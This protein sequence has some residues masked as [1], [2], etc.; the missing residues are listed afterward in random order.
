MTE[1]LPPR[2][3]IGVGAL[4]GIDGRFLLIRRGHPPRQGCW[5]LP[6]GRQEAGE[7]VEQAGRREIREET[8]VSIRVVDVLAVVDLMGG[9]DGAGYHYTVIDLEAEWTD[10][11]AV[12]GD[13]AA[14]LVWAH[15]DHLES[16]GLSPALLAVIASSVD[17]RR[18]G[19][20]APTLLSLSPAAASGSGGGGR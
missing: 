11:E 14:D 5:S 13:D 15:P 7:T 16:F 19:P 2:P 1:S 10:G 4:G 20:G 12:A 9:E 17:R 18:G 3:V 6:G 8:G